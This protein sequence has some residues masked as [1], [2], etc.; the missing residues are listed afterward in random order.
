M[1]AIPAICDDFN[2]ANAEPP[3]NAAEGWSWTQVNWSF[4]RINS[5]SLDANGTETT[6]GAV[7]AES[8]L[9]SADHYAKITTAFTV[10]GGGSSLWG[11]AARFD[12]AANTHYGAGWYDN[13]SSG[14]NYIIRCDAGTRTELW[15]DSARASSGDTVKVECDGSSIS[16][17][18][19][20]SLVHTLTDTGL[21]GG[22]RTGIFARY[23]D[24]AFDHDNFEAADLSAG[25]TTR[26]APFG[27]RGTAFNGGR[28]FMGVIR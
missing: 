16:H 8:A 23:T 20:G 4:W 10:Y 6:H 3:S 15:Y 19:N 25:G 26:G 5:N 13:G 27:T 2:R 9:S 11:A 17:Y 22:T 18:K 12:A 14:G 7:R 21:S 1:V 24:E 28:T